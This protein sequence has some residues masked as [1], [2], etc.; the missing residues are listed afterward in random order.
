MKNRELDGNLTSDSTGN[1]CTG[2]TF[3]RKSN[4]IP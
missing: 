2:N 1:T 3:C 4:N